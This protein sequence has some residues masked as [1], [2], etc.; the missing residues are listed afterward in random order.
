[1]KRILKSLAFALVPLAV[2]AGCTLS[3]RYDPLTNPYK[4]GS[5]A[6]LSTFEWPQG[7][8]EERRS[9]I[10][11]VTVV[12]GYKRVEIPVFINRCP[13]YEAGYMNMTT[14]DKI[15]LDR[16]VGN[17]I[18]WASFSF[19]DQVTV[20][21]EV[22][23]TTAVPVG[24]LVRVLPS[25][26]GVVTHVN[27]NKVSFTL[28]E[29][30]QF[31]LEIGDN[32]YKNGLMI[33][34]DPMET[35]PV[36]NNASGWTFLE[37][38]QDI[39]ALP[40]GTEN[41]YFKTGVHDV[42]VWSVPSSVRNIYFENGVWVYGALRLGNTSNVKM[43]GRGVLSSDRL[44]YRES[45]C[46]ETTGGANI[47]LEGI[48]VAD[49]KYFSVRLLS[50]NCNVNYTKVIGGWIYNCD[51]IVVYDNSTVSKCFTWANDDNMKV[52]MP[53]V[54][55][56]DMV[57]WQLNNGGAIQLGWYNATGQNIQLKR[58][59]LLHADWNNNESNN[60]GVISYVGNKPTGVYNA[61][62]AGITWQ[63][64]LLIEDLVVETAVP[65]VF[66]VAP[67][68]TSELPTPITPNTP[69]YVQGFT[70][71]NWD[72]K[73]KTPYVVNQ[74]LGVSETY[75]M[76]GFVFDNVYINGTKISA[77]SW[78]TFNFSTEFFDTPTFQ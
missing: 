3:D 23:N 77:E 74:I 67:Q 27:G 41:V 9:D 17:T 40:S 64:D 68:R 10:Y 78:S 20:E 22:L 4:V 75:K 26:Y 52:Y 62:P 58:I 47:T 14:T 38:G 5:D 46:I 1:M 13:V 60:R 57:L 32:G 39:T 15:P 51:G 30:A 33:F 12:Q 69:A 6:Q 36:V 43:Y 7:L 70:M 25:R 59:D 29:A 71:K 63:K 11:K 65:F 54:K 50:T 72:I 66:R 8:D 61:D 35:S 76:T 55:F 28:T 16:Y 2:L 53:N 49:P 73:V 31:S 45:H 18:S 48:T 42:A 37:P 24:G 34:A 21:V 44:N 19:E 56:E